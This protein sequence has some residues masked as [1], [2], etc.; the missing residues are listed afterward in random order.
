MRNENEL[1]ELSI[2]NIHP[3]SLIFQIKTSMEGMRVLFK[4]SNEC[5]T[6]K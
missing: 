6:L 4:L 5:S 1:F 3:Y 2:Q